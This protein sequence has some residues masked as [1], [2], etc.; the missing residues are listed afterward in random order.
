MSKTKL[1][2]GTFDYCVYFGEEIDPDIIHE[3]LN[4]Y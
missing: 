4:I 3:N 2:E 1:I